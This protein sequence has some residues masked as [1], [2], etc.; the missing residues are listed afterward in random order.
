MRLA[1]FTIGDLGKASSRLR[2]FYLFRHATSSNIEVLR[3]ISY[4]EACRCQIIHL[5]KIMDFQIFFEVPM[6]VRSLLEWIPILFLKAFLKGFPSF[7]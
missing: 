3:N 1:A 7:L 2:S 4:Q 5:Q 6:Q